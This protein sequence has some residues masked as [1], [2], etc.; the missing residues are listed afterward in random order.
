MLA[1]MLMKLC[2]IALCEKYFEVAEVCLNRLQTLIYLDS[3][4]KQM[5]KTTEAE[6]NIRKELETLYDEDAFE[7]DFINMI[8][9]CIVQKQVLG[10]SK[11][12][13][14]FARS[15]SQL[16]LAENYINYIVQ[17]KKL[18]EKHPKL[19][20]KGKD[21]FERLESPSKREKMIKAQKKSGMMGEDFARL[22]NTL[23]ICDG[24]DDSFEDF[25]EFEEDMSFN[26]LK[27]EPVRKQKIGRNEPCPCGSGKKYKQCCGRN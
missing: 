25:D 27:Q 7:E 16:E 6:L 11:A 18:K 22:M 2:Q 17:I 3:E 9:F 5:I 13:Y 1:G 26:T 15:M 10:I 24:F 20:D 23:G 12:E 19:Y 14:E 8:T 4:T 21:F